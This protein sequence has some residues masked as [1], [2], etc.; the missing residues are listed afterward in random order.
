MVSVPNSLG[1]ALSNGSLQTVPLAAAAGAISSADQLAVQIWRRQYKLENV[2]RKGEMNREIGR[3]NTLN[4]IRDDFRKK[5]YPSE[6]LRNMNFIGNAIK[7]LQKRGIS[8]NKASD[9]AYQALGWARGRPE[10]PSATNAIDA[11]SS[12]QWSSPDFKPL[13]N[14]RAVM[15]E[16]TRRFGTRQESAAFDDYMRN[17]RRRANGSDLVNLSTSPKLQQAMFRKALKREYGHVLK[18]YAP[19][20]SNRR[21]FEQVMRHVAPDLWQKLRKTSRDHAA[22]QA[23]LARFGGNNG[24]NIQKNN[25][26]NRPNGGRVDPN[27]VRRVRDRLIKKYFGADPDETRGVPTRLMSLLRPGNWLQD[28]TGRVRVT[29]MKREELEQRRREADSSEATYRKLI[30][31]LRPGDQLVLRPTVSVLPNTFISASGDEYTF[32]TSKGLRTVPARY[33]VDRLFSN[34]NVAQVLRARAKNV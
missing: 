29:P 28:V 33:L 22:I 34:K 6:A 8:R 18:T 31:D 12:Q 10:F 23:R 4:K 24:G 13:A 19:T 15:Y 1:P 25:D 21:E 20:H 27:T 26:G 32:L 17:A 14:R 2:G 9:V 11:V 5:T 7:E 16:D 3:R 30:A